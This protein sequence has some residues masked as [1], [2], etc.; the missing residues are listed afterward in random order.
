MRRRSLLKISIAITFCFLISFP[1]LNT[2]FKFIPDTA[3][4]ENRKLHS[5]PDFNVAFLDPYPFQMDSFCN[6]HFNLRN[7]LL[8]HFSSFKLRVFN[9]SPF[10]ERVFVGWDGWLFLTYSDLDAYQG[11]NNFTKTDLE[12]IRLE[13]EYRKA[14]LDSIG[15]KFYFG[16][17]PGKPNIYPEKMPYYLSRYSQKGW[18]EQLL[19]YLDKYG[20][21]S[22]VNLYDTLRKKKEKNQLYYKL[23]THWNSWGAYYAVNAFVEQVMADQPGLLSYPPD[24]FMVTKTINGDGNCAKL[25]GYPESMFDTVYKF[26]PLAPHTKQIK[27]NIWQNPKK[28]GPRIVVM[29]DSFCYWFV[30]LITEKFGTTIYSFDYRKYEFNREQLLEWKPD[31][32]LLLIH[33]PLLKKIQKHSCRPK[34]SVNNNP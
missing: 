11:K 32:L 28:P 33:E 7:R 25:L 4:L 26:V 2:L 9:K 27:D 3:S 23:D 29:G 30:P 21:I 14:V 24:S 16:V 15:C 8:Q 19:S 17:A 1:L 31:I 6:D 18:G 5:L 22:T 12:E 10:P 34:N 20:T 13:L